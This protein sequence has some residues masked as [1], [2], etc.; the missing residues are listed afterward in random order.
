MC[1]HVNEHLQHPGILQACKCKVTNNKS[2]EKN[3]L[4]GFSRPF[5]VGKQS[6]ESRQKPVYKGL[7]L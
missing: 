3:V 2:W 1:Q 5:P 6:G 7:L 4:Y